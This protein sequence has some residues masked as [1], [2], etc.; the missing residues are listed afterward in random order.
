MHPKLAAKLPE[1]QHACSAFPVKR[2]RLFGSAL[3]PDPLSWFNDVDV[4]VELE[5]DP[6]PQRRF[7][8]FF[9]LPRALQAV[10]HRPV[11]YHEWHA[12]RKPALRATIEATAEV[13]YAA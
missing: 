4:V 1:I 9:D 7:D 3:N 2:V 6:D 12:L 11:D 8:C 13:L 5:D 10:V